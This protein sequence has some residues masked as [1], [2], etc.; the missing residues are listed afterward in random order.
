V[1]ISAAMNDTAPTIAS[2]SR[3]GLAT[4]NRRPAQ[5]S[6]S[7][8][9]SGLLARK[10]PRIRDRTAA[11]PT[12]DAAFRAKT[13]PAPT[14]ANRTPPIAGPMNVPVRNA[15]AIVP[16]AHESSSSV[17]RFGTE[18]LAAGPAGNANRAA[19]VPRAMNKAGAVVKTIAVNVAAP[20]SSE[21]ISKRR[22]SKRSAMA[23]ATGERNPRGTWTKK[24]L[25]ESQIAECVCR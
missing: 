1:E 22:R 11:D 19:T 12:N 17:I 21:R 25:A 14:P 10:V 3:T 4:M 18:A 5:T 24:K 6:P 7:R 9:G 16:L 2:A 15:A 13:A 20:R 8:S 23:P